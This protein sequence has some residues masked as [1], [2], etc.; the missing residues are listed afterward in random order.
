MSRNIKQYNI[1]GDDITEEMAEA[2]RKRRRSEAA[3][4][5][6]ETRRTKEEQ[7]RAEYDRMFDIARCTENGDL[8]G[9][10]PTPEERAAAEEYIRTH[11][12]KGGKYGVL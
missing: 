10:V 9:N 2:E 5:G 4:T 12:R 6:W 3:K 8:F 1:F 7:E 11:K